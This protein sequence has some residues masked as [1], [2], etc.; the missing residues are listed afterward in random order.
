ME[1]P[2]VPGL[3]FNPTGDELLAHYLKQRILDL[4]SGD[5]NYS[6]NRHLIPDIELYNWD[7]EDL[8]TQYSSLSRTRCSGRQWFFFCRRVEKYRN[9]NRS[10]RTVSGSGYWKITGSDTKVTSEDTGAEIGKK[11][12]LT[13]YRGRIPNGTMTSWG[14]HEYHLNPP[15]LGYNNAEEVLSS[16]LQSTLCFSIFRVT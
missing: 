16:T 15:C 9:S 12:K 4:R 14:M 8:P 7:P 13:F 1:V 10:E 2:N 6:T 11:K 5:P 3:N